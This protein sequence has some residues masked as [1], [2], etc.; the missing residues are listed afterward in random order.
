M[1]ITGLILTF[2]IGIGIG[3]SLR[4]L[5]FERLDWNMLKWDENVLAYRL[6]GAGCRIHK[7]DKVFMA[8]RI[9]TDRIPNEGVKWE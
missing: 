7:N 3:F 1:Y 8:V 9:P 5:F 4:G 2:I 6:T